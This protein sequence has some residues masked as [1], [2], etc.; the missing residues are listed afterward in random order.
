M[1]RLRERGVDSKGALVS[2]AGRSAGKTA[3]AE[4]LGLD[5]APEATRDTAI[6]GLTT[7]A[8]T[9]M[10]R[11]S[12]ARAAAPS[13]RMWRNV[14][15]LTAAKLAD[16]GVETVDDL[17]AADPAAI[18]VKTGMDADAVKRLVDAAR[19]ESR[20]SLRAGAIATVSRTEEKKLKD[21]LGAEGATVGVLAR[22]S[23]AEIAAAFGG[24]LARAE[25]VLRGIAAGL[26]QRGVR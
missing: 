23:A 2:F 21:L 13:V 20:A 12:V 17:G 15:A 22:K 11:A 25:A 18:A 4:A 16:A 6:N 7:E 24:N 10:T 14:D 26:A 3:I 9:V 19:T 1:Q 8:V 5:S